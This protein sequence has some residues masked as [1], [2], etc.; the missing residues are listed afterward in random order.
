MKYGIVQVTPPAIEV[1]S[2]D[3]GGGAKNHLRVEVNADDAII[4]AWIVAARQWIEGAI[5][6]PLITQTWRQTF[7][8]FPAV[9]CL[10]KPPVQSVASVTYIDT[11]GVT[12]TLD[13]SK[14]R[15]VTDYE[16]AIVEPAYNEVWP[17][18]RLVSGGVS[19][20][21]VA[22]YGDDGDSVPEP[23]LAAMRL[24]IGHLY[25]N[26]EENV[27]RALAALPFGVYALLGPYTFPAY[28]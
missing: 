25:E 16:P 10:E 5:N 13:A 17:T 22:G 2:L 6:R 26:R 3:G 15:V 20:T 18:T 9:I 12:Q 4:N 1:L 24:I 21:F 14:Y 8:T 27:E 23:I 7:D 28:R 11:D 19:V